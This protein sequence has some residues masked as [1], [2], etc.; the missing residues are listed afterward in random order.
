MARPRKGQE[1]L[2]Y[3]G[4]VALKPVNQ[5]VEWTQFE[6]D[7]YTKCATDIKYFI[8][9]Y[10]R[11][12]NVDFGLI[13]FNLRDYQHRMVDSIVEN[14]YT[15]MLCSRQVGK[16]QHAEEIITLRNKTTGKIFKT[17]IGEFYENRKK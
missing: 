4:N 16:C 2:G 5:K 12:E 8:N 11:I 6:F 15:I 7:E 9:N 10:V 1:P 13:N 3:K 14:R 17:T